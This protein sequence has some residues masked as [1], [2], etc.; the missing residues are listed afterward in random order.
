[1]TVGTLVTNLLRGDDVD[2][3][4]AVEDDAV[5][6]SYDKSEEMTEEAA[7]KLVCFHYGEKNP[8]KPAF[9]E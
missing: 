2:D 5:Y 9:Q 4:E 3:D 6:T 1:M 7:P 8:P